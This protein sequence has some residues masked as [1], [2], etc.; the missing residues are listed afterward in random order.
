M[1]FIGGKLIVVGRKTL[2]KRREEKERKKKKLINFILFQKWPTNIKKYFL[3]FHFCFQFG[4]NQKSSTQ[5]SMQR[6]SNHRRRSQL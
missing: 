2:K 3:T 5:L 4:A 1:F 6:V